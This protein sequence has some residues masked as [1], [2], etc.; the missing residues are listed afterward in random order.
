MRN[1][2][3]A[4]D[5]YLTTVF[6]NRKKP[7]EPLYRNGFAGFSIFSEICTESLKALQ[8]QGFPFVCQKT[9]TFL[10]GPAEIRRKALQ[11]GALAEWQ[12]KN[13]RGLTTV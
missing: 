13:C 10:T 3:V 2:A 6:G 5:Y 9:P 8:I 4:S 12:R 1:L 7:A 11:T